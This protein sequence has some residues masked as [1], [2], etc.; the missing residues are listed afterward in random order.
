MKIRN[1]ELARRLASPLLGLAVLLAFGLTACDSLGLDSDS[2]VAVAFRTASGSNGSASV[3]G[4]TADASLGPDIDAAIQFS[5]TNGTL[6]FE[7]AHIVVSEFELERVDAECDSVANEDACEEFEADPQFL[8]LPLD[9]G[10]AVAV[11]Q[12]VPPGEYDELEFEVDDLEDDD[13][14][15]DHSAEQLL[16]QDIRSQFAD[17]PEN[18]TLRVT[19]TFTPADTTED[20]RDFTAYFEAEIEIEKEFSTPLVIEEG[21]GNQ[22]VTVTVDPAVWFTM[23]DGS[24]VD[25]SQYDF[26]STGSVAEFEVEME[27]GFTEMEFED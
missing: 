8:E 6:E 24:V 16:L 3:S 27:D 20:A 7:T 11:N 15:D 17:W 5:G 19:G 21:T 25:L 26:E 18:G 22:T 13:E 2:S 10:T 4:Q 23:A 1:P 9:G 14:G 12:T